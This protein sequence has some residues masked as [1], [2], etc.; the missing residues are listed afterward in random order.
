MSAGAAPSP[1]PRFFLARAGIRKMLIACLCF[2]P[3]IPLLALAAINVGLNLPPTRQHL[4]LRI[5]SISGQTCNFGWIA[6]SPSGGIEVSRVRLAAARSGNRTS[7]LLVVPRIVIDV[8]FSGLI[9][10]QFQLRTITLDRPQLNLNRAT[11]APILASLSAPAGSGIAGPPPT[12]LASSPP[13]PSLSE[14]DDP[15][16][17]PTSATSP[18]PAVIEGTAAMPQP[19][20]P[21]PP[22]PTSFV[23]AVRDGRV[24]MGKRGS[25]FLLNAEIPLAGPAASGNLHIRELRLAGQKFPD[26]T[27]PDITLRGGEFDFRVQPL[28]TRANGPTGAAQLRVGLATGF[29]ISL[30]VNFP[31]QEIHDLALSEQMTL[32]TGTFQADLAIVGSLA[33]PSAMLVEGLAQASSCRV[34]FDGEIRRF[35]HGQL[36]VIGRNGILRVVDARLL[37]DSLSL[38]ANG[39]IHTDGR[40]AAVVRIVGPPDDVPHLTRLLLPDIAAPAPEPSAGGQRAVQDIYLIGGPDGYEL[41]LSISAPRIPLADGVRAGH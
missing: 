3:A 25:G 9:R 8:P 41:G 38:L 4:S 11:L 29:P 34:R 24:R 26:P 10:G 30:R 36:I 1:R 2:G 5:E 22:G 7:P 21:P 33:Q 19:A 40:A 37:G 16:P 35:D 23:V 31:T 12:A 20:R 27:P 39:E 32:E 15:P 13:T 14:D 17:L 18:Q 6:W 28:T